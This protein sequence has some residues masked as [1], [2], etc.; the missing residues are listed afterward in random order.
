[1]RKLIIL[2]TLFHFGCQENLPETPEQEFFNLPGFTQNVLMNLDNRAAD[3]SKRFIL[4][5]KAETQLISSTDSTFWAKELSA[6]RK[7]DLNAAKFRGLLKISEGNR[8]PNSN[9]LVDHISTTSNDFEFK[10]IDIFYLDSHEHI[11]LI[12][13]E[14]SSKNFFTKSTNRLTVW[15]NDYNSQLLV[16]S[17]VTRANDKVMFQKERIY[18]SHV[19]RVRQ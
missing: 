10:N 2:L 7:T 4:N 15:F 8:D 19:I 5:G 11:R 18:E 16:D 3:V 13:L 12:K 14:Y 1:M 9:L 17:L 6:L